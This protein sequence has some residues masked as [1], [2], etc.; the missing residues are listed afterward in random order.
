M[1]PTSVTLNEHFARSEQKDRHE[2][3]KGR[4]NKMN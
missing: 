1:A 2:E 4:D 3:H